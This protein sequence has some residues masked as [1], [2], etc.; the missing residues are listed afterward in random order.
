[1]ALLL[2][3]SLLRGL[4]TGAMAGAL[5]FTVLAVLS[6]FGATLSGRTASLGALLGLV[7]LGA[8]GGMLLG[9]AA[10]AAVAVMLQVANGRSGDAR[11]SDGRRRVLAA[12]AAG[13]T[14]LGLTGLSALSGVPGLLG[15]EPMTAVLLP[16]LVAT[17]VAASVAP[18]L[19]LR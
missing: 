3:A 15:P 11:I 8:V 10:G 14:V 17:W 7:L 6:L 2:R 9:V 1:M 18:D 13:G 19:P 12:A 4:R 5:Y 16:T